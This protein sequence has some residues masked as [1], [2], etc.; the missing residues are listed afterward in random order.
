MLTSKT[1]CKKSY[2]KRKCN[3]SKWKKI[4]LRNPSAP[5]IS[6]SKSSLMRQGAE[7]W[8]YSRMR[9]REEEGKKQFKTCVISHHN[10]VAKLLLLSFS[11]FSFALFHH[12]TFILFPFL[13]SL[14]ERSWRIQQPILSPAIVMYNNGFKY[15]NHRRNTTE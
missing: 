9:G 6:Q 15:I 11:V 14:R 13:R 7:M 2:F 10:K 4:K 3:Q 8:C 1:K 12:L 5:V